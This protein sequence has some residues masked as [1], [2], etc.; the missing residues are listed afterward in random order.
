MIKYLPKSKHKWK[1]MGGLN[2]SKTLENSMNNSMI[3]RKRIL[4]KQLSNLILTKWEYLLHK[5]QLC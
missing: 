5:M 1:D 2:Y 4:I 3:G